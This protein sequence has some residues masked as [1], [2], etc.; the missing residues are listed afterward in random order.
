[1]NECDNDLG[2]M[3]ASRHM[4]N[5]KVDDDHLKLIIESKC[6]LDSIITKTPSI[7]PDHMNILFIQL[8]GNY[9]F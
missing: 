4:T 8:S 9:I 3:E 5:Q 1:M 6:A 7:E 2:N